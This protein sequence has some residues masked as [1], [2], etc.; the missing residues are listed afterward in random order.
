MLAD[1]I[2]TIDG[3]RYYF[4]PTGVMGRG[5]LRTAE[6]SRFF[7][8][9]T[10][11]ML[12]DGIYTIDGQRYYFR[13]TGIMGRGWLTRQSSRYFFNRSNGTML[14]SGM[15]DVDGN[16]YYFRSS[17]VMGKGWLTKGS[18]KY[19]FDRSSGKMV[20]NSIF[21]V[22]GVWYVAG[23]NG[24]VTP[25]PTQHPNMLRKAQSY[26]SS[27]GWL[28]LVDCSAN[29]CCIYR[30]SHGNWVTVKEWACTT[31][32]SGTP[33]KKGVFSVGSKGYSFGNGFTC[34][35]YTQFYH[36]YLF[37][38]VLYYPG[39]FRVMDG[40]LGINASHGCVRLDINNAQYIYYNVPS[41]STVVTY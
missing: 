8:R 15:H 19:F 28:I 21:S 11:R 24:K 12:A 37:H 26:F 16:T 2:Y 5:W 27:T 31:G 25:S 10:G 4:R 7:S 22:D 41:G 34:Y 35:Y 18:D 20:R 36:D 9:Q 13:P 33:T 39:T 30:G 1:G 6:C 38:S 17:G 23:S 29:R 3:Q 40:R 32:A 14:H